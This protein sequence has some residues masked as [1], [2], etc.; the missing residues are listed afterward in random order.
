MT[1]SVFLDFAFGIIF[2]AGGALLAFNISRARDR[3]SEFLHK[4]NVPRA[5]RRSRID[6]PRFA[7]AYGLMFLSGGLLLVVVAVVAFFQR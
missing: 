3:Y 4:P 7:T 1:Y 6:E 2:I 5:W